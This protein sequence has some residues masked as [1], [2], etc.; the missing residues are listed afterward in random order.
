MIGLLFVFI[1]GC[2]AFIFDFYQFY[3]NFKLSYYY[4]ETFLKNNDFLEMNNF[5]YLYDKNIFEL[6]QNI[7]KERLKKN[8]YPKNLVLIIVSVVDYKSIYFI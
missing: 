1:L 4:H 8:N 6:K 3:R 2:L 5:D 7:M